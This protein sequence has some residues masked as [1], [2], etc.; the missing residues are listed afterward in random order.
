MDF[1]T[2]KP[3]DGFGHSTSGRHRRFKTQ[4]FK[5]EGLNDNLDDEYKT[6]NG[7]PQEH[8]KKV[9][10][11]IILLC[12]IIGGSSIGPVSNFI[13][14]QSPFAKNAWRAGI[15]C[16]YFCIP[17]LIE[18]YVLSRRKT[19]GTKN[20]FTFKKYLFFQATLLMQVLWVF[21]LM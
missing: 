7:Q 11:V 4:T 14:I 10:G 15:I 1:S 3:Q 2:L 19:T 21:G 16:C 12:S 8:C 17:S 18:I 13:P 6:D 9:V 5:I 20:M